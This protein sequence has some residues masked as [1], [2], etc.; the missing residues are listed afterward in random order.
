MTHPKTSLLLRM[1]NISM[2]NAGILSPLFG[3]L[4][5]RKVY[6]ERWLEA[7]D[8][9]TKKHLEEVIDRCNDEIKRLLIL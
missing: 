6:A 4:A 7:T 1:E 2:Q 3:V 8:E 5:V 9:N